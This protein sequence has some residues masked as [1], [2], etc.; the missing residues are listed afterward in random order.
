MQGS[1]RFGMHVKGIVVSGIV[2]H[3][4]RRILGIGKRLKRGVGG[5]YV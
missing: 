5:D 3:G 4:Q 2:Q 1:I